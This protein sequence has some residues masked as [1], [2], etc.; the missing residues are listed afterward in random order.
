M[1]LNLIFLPIV[2]TGLYYAFT[3]EG[4]FF[5]AFFCF[6]TQLPYKVQFCQKAIVFF[7]KVL[8][9]K[10]KLFLF[11]STFVNQAGRCFR[12]S[13]KFSTNLQISAIFRNMKPSRNAILSSS[14]NK[15]YMGLK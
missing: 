7:P 3:F 13:V 6:Q 15:A 4:N 2:R 14:L 10:M 1:L 8:G 12:S 5:V 9:K 11:I